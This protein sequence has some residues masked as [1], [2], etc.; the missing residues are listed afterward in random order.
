MIYKSKPLNLGAFGYSRFSRAILTADADDG[1]RYRVSFDGGMNFRAVNLNEPFRV[2]R[3]GAKVVVEI[4]FESSTPDDMY[5][6]NASGVF[7]LQQGTEVTFT[8][9]K[10]AFKTTLGAAG[11][12]NISLPRSLYTVTYKT[13]NTTETIA[14]NY[15]P[16][17][18]TFRHSDDFDKET[19]IE[20]FMSRIEW[21]EVAVY[22]TFVNS[23]KVSR[24]STA[25]VDL[26]QTLTDGS[27]SVRYWALILK[28]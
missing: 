28:P 18:Y 8:S 5:V 25:Q 9:A 4:T 6:V 19:A 10:G 12:Y 15:D 17:Q 2:T 7:P 24:G 22:D 27:K 21:G 16:A 1:I 23:D 3:P 14:E 26:R 11:R 20:A 13:I